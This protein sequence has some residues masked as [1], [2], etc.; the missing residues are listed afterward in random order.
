MKI[1][2]TPLILLLIVSVMFLSSCVSVSQQKSALELT[3]QWLVDEH[4]QLL[5]DPQPSGL[6]LSLIHI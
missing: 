3:G 6:T 4:N 5:L 2:K 1:L